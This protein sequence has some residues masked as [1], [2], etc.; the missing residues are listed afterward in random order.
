MLEIGI[1]VYNA[2]E[3]LAKALD[4]LVAQTQNNFIV[5]LS[6]DGD[7]GNYEFYKELTNKY[8]DRGLKMRIIYNE[9]N[10]GPGVARQRILDTTQCDYIMFLDSDDML[11]PRAVALLYTQAKAGNYDIV[12]S[13]F[14]REERD[15]QDMMLPQNINTITWFHGKIYR[16][17]YLKEKDIRFH[18]DLRADEDAFFNLIAWNSAP[19]RGETSEVTYIWRFNE[20]SITRQTKGKEYFLKTYMYY[21][22]S[23]V[24]GLIRLSEL[25]PELDQNLITQTVINIYNYYMHA[26]FYQV[27]E[28]NM[29]QLISKLKEQEQIQNC[30]KNISSWVY[31]V[32]NLKAGDI[33]DDVNIVFFSEPFNEWI[34]RL[35]I[36]G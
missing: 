28:T 3:T 10:R 9:E 5:C 23:Q 2:K 34:K 22:T 29:I 30:F 17:G 1:P 25:N 7:D 35:I 21:L 6:I 20:N 15:K 36:N 14:I 12:R 18:P 24:E 13:S 16:V 33:Y 11:M 31:I 19:N 8:I 26:R 32:K 4:S 27:D